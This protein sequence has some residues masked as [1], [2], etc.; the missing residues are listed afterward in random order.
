[1]TSAPSTGPQAQRCPHAPTCTPCPFRGLAYGEQLA[2]KR[3]MLADALARYPSLAGAGIEEPVGSRDL[4]GYRNVAKLV[5]RGDRDGRL[6]AG[7]YE[8]GSHRFADA[9]GCS[10]HHPAINEAL[11]AALA[12]ASRLGIPA[13]DERSRHGELRYLVARY[14]AFT[15]KVLL[16]L[17]TA[18]RE[19]GSFRELVR[20]LPKRC[21][22]IGGIVQNV[23]ADPGNVIFGRQWATLRPPAGLLERIGPFR[24]ATSPGAF[25][26]ANLWTARRIYETVVAS[27]DPRP[28]ET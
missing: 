26:Q 12:E 6:R 27:A 4:F 11:E 3:R 21:R 15:R 5:V 17:V 22:S 23:N 2:R 1:M 13:Y 19:R 20:R 8:P 9:A 7:V 18:S 24:L 25:L 14:S 28:D 16:I 10:V